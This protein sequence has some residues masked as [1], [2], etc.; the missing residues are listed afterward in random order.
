MRNTKAQILRHQP[1]DS[2]QGGEPGIPWD[3]ASPSAGPIPSG[4]F[5]NAQGEAEELARA[6]LCMKINSL[7]FSTCSVL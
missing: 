1:R 4:H 5:A 3:A 6:V 2:L 7:V